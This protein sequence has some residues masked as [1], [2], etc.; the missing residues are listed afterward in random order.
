MATEEEVAPRWPEGTQVLRY[1]W[2]DP[3]V[4]IRLRAAI[5]IRVYVTPTSNRLHRRFELERAVRDLTDR[6]TNG[7]ANGQEDGSRT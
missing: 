7:H 5:E 2:Y 1:G 3:D 4:D 6:L